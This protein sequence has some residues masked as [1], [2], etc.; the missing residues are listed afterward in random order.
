MKKLLAIIIAIVIMFWANSNLFSEHYFDAS[1]GKNSDLDI[2]PSYS[3]AEWVDVGYLE[4]AH[5][6]VTNVK[7]EATEAE[8]PWVTVPASLFLEKMS[9][10]QLSENWFELSNSAIVT[11]K[12][13]EKIR[14]VIA[15]AGD[16]RWREWLSPEAKLIE[17]SLEFLIKVRDEQG[18]HTTDYMPS[19]CTT[20]I[21]VE[22][23]Q[24]G[25]YSIYLHKTFVGKI[26]V[27]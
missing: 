25:E 12:S 21:V 27:I 3:G 22:N 14:F 8:L 13:Q 10:L 15:N 7:D 17:N 23:L 11:L 2:G 18:N 5:I 1:T 20:S 26:K 19:V 9:D 16:F 6:Y 4:N 24:K